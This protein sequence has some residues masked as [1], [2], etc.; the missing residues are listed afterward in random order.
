MVFI[1]SSGD[2]KKID[3][4]KPSVVRTYC[5]LIKNRTNGIECPSHKETLSLVYPPVCLGRLQVFASILGGS[6]I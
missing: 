6:K 3:Y 5:D 1:L 2:H 4:T